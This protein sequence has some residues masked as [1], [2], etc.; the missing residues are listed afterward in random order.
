MVDNKEIY[1]D[2]ITLIYD[3]L[4]KL[5]HQVKNPITVMKL[6]L[7]DEDLIDRNEMSLELLKIE[8]YLDMLLPIVQIHSNNTLLLNNS[9]LDGILR[10]VIRKF[11]LQFQHKNLKLNYLPPDFY[12]NI[13]EK[14]L[15]AA[16]SQLIDNAIKFT[17]RGTVSIYPGNQEDFNTIIIEDTGRGIEEDRINDIFA[18]KSS[19]IGLYLSK[20]LLE[21][22]SCNITIESSLEVGTKVK[23]YFPR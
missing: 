10:Q 9:S 2:K 11:S 16:I 22:M 19:C 3:D 15:I 4:R 20:S 12:V 7:Q 13:N 17:E 6:I 23:I 21:I 18:Q 1:E 8:T 14:L 5:L